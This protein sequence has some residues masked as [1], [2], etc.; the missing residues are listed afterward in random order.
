MVLVGARRHRGNDHT[1]GL[2]RGSDDGVTRG[3]LF[4]LLPIPSL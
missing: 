1:A 2:R 3:A 4:H